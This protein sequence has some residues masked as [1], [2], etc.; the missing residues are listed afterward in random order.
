M[1]FGLKMKILTL[2]KMVWFERASDEEQNGANMR[3]VASSSE[4]LYI[5]IPVAHSNVHAW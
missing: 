1:V 2:A 4:E 5:P 3:S